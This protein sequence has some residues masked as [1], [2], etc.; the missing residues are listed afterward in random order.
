MTKYEFTVSG[1]PRS[2]QAQS[3]EN[4]YGQGD[5]AT[6]PEGDGMPYL[7]KEK[8]TPTVATRRFPPALQL[9]TRTTPMVEQQLWAV[10]H[11][12]FREGKTLKQICVDVYNYA[13]ALGYEATIG[14]QEVYSASMPSYPGQ[15]IISALMLLDLRPLRMTG[16]SWMGFAS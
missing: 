12:S 7:R 9:L 6:L 10:S 1:T 4:G 3:E 15:T 11:Q 5:G 16:D 14:V 13:Q 8:I 2:Q